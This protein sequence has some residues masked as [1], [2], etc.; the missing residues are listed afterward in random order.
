MGTYFEQDRYKR[1]SL[2][3]LARPVEISGTDRM[4]RAIDILGCVGIEARK[5]Q[6]DLQTAQFAG[7]D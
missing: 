7:M 6:S 1:K 5:P 3:C 4:T 2:S